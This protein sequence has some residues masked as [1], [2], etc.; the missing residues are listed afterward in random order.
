MNS[1]SEICRDGWWSQE[2]VMVMNLR[3]GNETVLG[4]EVGYIQAGG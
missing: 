1:R 3:E 4:Y 2:F